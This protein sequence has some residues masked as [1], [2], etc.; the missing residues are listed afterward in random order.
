MREQ[1]SFQEMVTQFLGRHLPASGVSKNTLKAYRDTIKLMLEFASGTCGITPV[2]MSVESFTANFVSQFLTWLIET[3][4]CSPRTRNQRLAGIHSFCKYIQFRS[5]E[6]L[7]EIGKILSIRKMRETH[8]LVPYLTTEEMKIMLA[9]PDVAT[10]SGRRDLAIL[11]ALYDSGARVQELSDIRIKDVRLE[12]PALI[13]LHGKGNKYRE[14]PIMKRTQDILRRHIAERTANLP[15]SVSAD[16]LYLFGSQ[17]NDK[18]SRWGITH[19]IKKYERSLRKA[20]K[21]NLPFQ[22]TPHVFRHTKAMHALKAGVPL[23]Y[24]R[25]LLGHNSVTTTEIYAR[26]NVDEKRKALENIFVDIGA[27]KLPDWREDKSLMDWLSRL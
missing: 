5:P 3:R 22:I 12:N 26:A 13:V 20:G 21:L 8:K 27:A 2:K 6:T 15:F 11:T 19:V 17:R 24:I 10:K 14:V 1:Y 25:D 23:I 9:A 16:T 18:I 7:V 4:K